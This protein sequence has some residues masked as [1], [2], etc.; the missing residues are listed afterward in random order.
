MVWNCTSSYGV[1]ILI[2]I[3][4]ILDKNKYLNIL[5]NNL[6]KSASNIGFGHGFKL[7]QNNNYKH[8]VRKQEFLLYNCKNILRLLSQSSILMR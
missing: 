4:D 6:L 2:F 5:Q 7:Y 8:K 1:G 3:D